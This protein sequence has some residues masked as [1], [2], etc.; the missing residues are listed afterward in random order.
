L[1]REQ[2]GKAQTA[3]SESRRLNFQEGGSAGDTKDARMQ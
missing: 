2:R 3:E 1:I